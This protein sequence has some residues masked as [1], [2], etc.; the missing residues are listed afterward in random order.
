MK[1]GRMRKEPWDSSNS[2]AGILTCDDFGSPDYVSE[3][4]KT[5]RTASN[6]YEAT[7]IL[8]EIIKHGPYTS[9]I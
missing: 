8:K 9:K 6:R 2:K 5:V 4:A 7:K 1:E 3:Q